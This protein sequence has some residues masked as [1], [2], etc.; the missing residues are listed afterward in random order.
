MLSATPYMQ[1]QYVYVKHVQCHVLYFTDVNMGKYQE[2]QPKQ[3]CVE[4]SK[5]HTIMDEFK[6][7]SGQDIICM[8]NHSG[9]K[10]E[11]YIN[12]Q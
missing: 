5:I 2:M 3:S 10:N 4:T 12:I 1:F 8:M 6:Q 9:F 7:Q 11:S